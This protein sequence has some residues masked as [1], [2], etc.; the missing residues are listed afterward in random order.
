MRSASIAVRAEDGVSTVHMPAVPLEVEVGEDRMAGRCVE[1]LWL[2][3]DAGDV[4]RHGGRVGELADHRAGHQDVVDQFGPALVD[5][6]VVVG[7]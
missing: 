3:A 7:S 4:E 1:Q 6:R 2:D 5:A